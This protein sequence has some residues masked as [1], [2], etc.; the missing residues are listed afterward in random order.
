MQ[1]SLHGQ[2]ITLKGLQS[3]TIHY[4]LKRQ[5]SRMLVSIYKGI[6]TLLLFRD[7][8]LYALDLSNQQEWDDWA[9]IEF[10]KLLQQYIELFEEPKGLPLRRAHDHHIQLNDET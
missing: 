6:G 3:G 8:S 10:Q 2:Q 4:A 7:P 5:F 1:F 9:T